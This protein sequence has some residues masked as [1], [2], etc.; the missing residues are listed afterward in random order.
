MA[1]S[2]SRDDDLPVWDPPIYQPIELTAIDVED[3]A[4]LIVSH[5]DRYADEWIDSNCF[6]DTYDAR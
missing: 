1:Q 6:V 3:G 5:P 2:H 4:R